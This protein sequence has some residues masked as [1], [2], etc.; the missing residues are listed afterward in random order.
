MKKIDYHN[1]TYIE[2]S[3]QESV[4]LNAVEPF[5]LFSVQEIKR[6]TGWKQPR[7]S[8]VLSSLKK[9]KIVV[10]L[11]KNS[12]VLSAKIPENIWM[13]ATSMAAPAYISFWSA[14]SYYGLTEQQTSAIQIVSTKQ[15]PRF[16]IRNTP[17][18]ITTYQPQR[19]YGY[20]R[21]Q[22]FAIA[23]IEKLLIDCLY[24]PEKVGGIAELK[25]CLRQAWP[26]IAKNKFKA[27]L[28]RFNNR[29][30][31]ARAGYL[32][33]ELRLLPPNEKKFFLR[34]LP[35]GY[36]RLNPSKKP[37]QKYNTTWRIYIND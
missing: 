3:P 13:I 26:T 30:L 37:G 15:F 14:C 18:E 1:K 22:N 27:Y 11:R 6:I 36:V 17:V 7:I 12:Y 5:T 19:F 2:L 20:R 25:K 4:L 8:N 31:Y 16:R 34:Q 9:K 23:E 24:Q 32:L 10:A 28:H 35:S 21:I 29:S 33:E